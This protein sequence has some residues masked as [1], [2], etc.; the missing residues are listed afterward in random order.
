MTVPPPVIAANRAQLASLVATNFLG[1]NTPA[2]AATEAHYGEMWA[3]DAAAMYGYAGSSAAAT[4][5]HTVHARP[6]QT[7][8]AGAAGRPVRRGRPG[9][10]HLGRHGQR[11]R[12]RSC[13]AVPTTLQGLASPA[14]STSS[15]VTSSTSG[16]GGIW[17]LLT[18]GSSGNSAAGQLL[19]RVGAQREHLEHHIF[20]GVLHAEQHLGCLH[21]L[22]RRPSSWCGRR[23][24]RSGCE[25]RARCRRR[26][27]CRPAGR[28]G[29]ARGSGQ[30]GVGRSGQGSLARAIVG[31]AELDCD[32]ANGE[33]YR[34][35]VGRH[36]AIQ[37]SGSR[38][39]HARGP[40]WR[41]CPGAEQPA[42]PIWTTGFWL[43]PPDGAA[44]GR[45]RLTKERT[46]S[47]FQPGQS[48]WPTQQPFRIR[49]DSDDHAFYD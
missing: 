41:V 40:D 23:R 29:R 21:E 39:G 11:S 15:S 4:K 35:G 1:Q 3:Q 28:P 38:R 9:H 36:P 26:W 48:D 17:N 13:S 24:R 31:A 33:P 8:N 49:R 18:G 27:A 34:F 10:W 44:L 7:T 42:P 6:T 30:R 25:R 5:L 32:R 2:I 22:A 14:S 20:F 16:L 19:E 43:R 37:P 12:C 47:S 45:D 46:S